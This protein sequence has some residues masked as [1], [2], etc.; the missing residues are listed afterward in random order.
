MSALATAKLWFAHHH[1]Q[2]LIGG[3]AGVAGFALY[4]RHQ[5][6]AGGA[7]TPAGVT[8]T[9]A[10]SG[11]GYGDP[12]T[13]DST[14][15]DVDAAL[16][17]ADLTGIQGTLDGIRKTL[18]KL[19]RPGK[20]KPAKKTTKKPRRSKRAKAR[21]PARKVAKQTP[22]HK[23]PPRTR[24]DQA[25]RVKHASHTKVHKLAAQPASAY[26][27]RRPVNNPRPIN[28][29]RRISSPVAAPAPARRR[30]AAPAPIARKVTPAGRRHR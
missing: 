15:S 29:A 26:A 28:T 24:A 21:K 12:G 18:G 19:P 8:G 10:A 14:L 17:D 5:G 3:G 27:L 11:V 9:G 23:K 20:K 30:V 6:A 22:A 4:K 1:T 13:A 2:A 25:R 16:L 7:A